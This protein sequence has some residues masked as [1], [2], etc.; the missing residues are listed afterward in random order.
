MCVFLDGEVACECACVYVC[1]ILDGEVVCV[2][3]FG[4]G[5]GVCV[6]RACKRAFLK[7]PIIPVGSTR[8][9]DEF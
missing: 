5:G 6:V 1:V 9:C 7:H 8:L 2:C 4:W 3:V